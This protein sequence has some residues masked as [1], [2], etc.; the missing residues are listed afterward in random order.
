MLPISV[1]IPV[2]NAEK[3]IEETLQS[4]LNQSFPAAEVLVINDGSTD[5]TLAMLEKKVPDIRLLNKKN[6]GPAATLNE[7]IRSS[8]QPFIAFLDADDIW[9]PQK[10]E[11][12]WKHF[13]QTPELEISFG[14]LKQFISEEL[15]QAIKD[16]IY[17]PDHPQRG[18]IKGTM[19]ARRII[20]DK[21]GLFDERIQ[22]G[23]F[24]EWFAR[25]QETGVRY[26]FVE[27]VLMARRLHRSGL[28]NKREH[29]KDYAR[30][31]KIALDRRR[32]N[33]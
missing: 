24:I 30:L 2:Y 15:P 16:G 27:D 29:E 31:L 1:I 3:Y 10:L 7:G 32:Q 8:T 25:A 13:Q 28:T 5:G 26:E 19:L 22:W 11:I 21:V 23:D 17:C 9:A 33:Q 18:L 6:Q 20:F 14:W 12:Q 4:V